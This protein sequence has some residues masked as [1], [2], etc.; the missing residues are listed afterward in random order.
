MLNL[1]TLHYILNS[2]EL[3][4]SLSVNSEAILSN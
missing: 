1:M 4:A 3:R 2:M